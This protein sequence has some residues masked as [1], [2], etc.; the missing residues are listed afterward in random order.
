MNYLL[1]NFHAEQSRYIKLRPLIELNQAPL[2]AFTDR[3]LPG[4]DYRHSVLISLPML[5]Y[6]SNIKVSEL[7]YERIIIKLKDTGRREDESRV[8]DEIKNAMSPQNFNGLQFESVHRDHIAKAD[9][10]VS[11]FFDIIIIT[12]LFLSF[13]SL[14]STMSSNLY[15]QA[16]EIGVLRA[17][18][19]EKG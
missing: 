17:V 15:E 7:P 5:S 9:T 18:G 3:E 2:F 10:V 1:M 4:N 8:Y 11:N 13:F 19:L 12:T 16:K 14:S 6:F